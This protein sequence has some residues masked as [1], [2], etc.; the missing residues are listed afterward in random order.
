MIEISNDLIEDSASQQA[1]AVRLAR[2]LTEAMTVL[3]DMTGK[4]DRATDSHSG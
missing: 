3:A 1:M 4:A 2:L